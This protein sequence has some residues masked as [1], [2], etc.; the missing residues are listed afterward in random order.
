VSSERRVVEVAAGRQVRDDLDGDVR[1]R[2]APAKPGF[3]SGARPR[4]PREEVGGDT[5]GG[6]RVERA[7]GA[8]SPA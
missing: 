6:D 1:R 5:P 4:T 2:A 8:A 3:E 7:R